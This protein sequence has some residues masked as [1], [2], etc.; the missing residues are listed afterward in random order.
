[1]TRK[2]AERSK[3]Q[4]S[5]LRS[6]P[7]HL[8]SPRVDP[9]AEERSGSKG[10]RSPEEA[11]RELIARQGRGDAQAAPANSAGKPARE[12]TE[13]SPPVPTESPVA[14][15]AP[16]G[17]GTPPAMAV[18]AA[19]RLKRR[20]LTVP[21]LR[22]PPLPGLPRLR[23]LPRPPRASGLLAVRKRGYRPKRKHVIW[24]T[25][26]M[27]MLWRPLLLPGIAFVSFWILLIVYFTLGPDRVT[28]L[29][30]VMWHWLAARRPEQAGRIRGRAVAWTAKANA[31]TAKLPG[32]WA[33]RL[34]LPDLSEERADA[35]GPDPFERLAAEARRG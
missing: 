4:P 25:V 26:A 8:R 2:P 27:V 7:V 21:R 12:G 20:Q 1:M 34:H 23:K 35:D 33:E 10:D 28:E 16:A 24:A 14:D 17:A 5:D 11:I 19:N 32:M 30:S 15:K 18:G 31:L 6:G 29:I 22:P 3:Q 13:A 9:A